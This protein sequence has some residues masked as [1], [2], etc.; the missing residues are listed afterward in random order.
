MRNVNLT[1]CD[2]GGG[3]KSS[4]KYEFVNWDDE[5]HNIW[6]NTSHVPNHQPVVSLV[7][8]PGIEL[9]QKMVKCH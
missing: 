4:E 3:F 6:E 9:Q 8:K 7:N 2:L 1:C 5:I